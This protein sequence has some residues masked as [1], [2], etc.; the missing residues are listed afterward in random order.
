[1]PDK[2]KGDKTK[3]RQII[4]RLLFDD[5]ALGPPIDNWVKSYDTLLE[6]DK[7]PPVL[8]PVILPRFKMQDRPEESR[9]ASIAD[10]ARFW[11]TRSGVIAGAAGSTS[12]ADK[13]GIKIPLSN[14]VRSLSSP[15][16]S[17]AGLN[18]IV[19]CMQQSLE[20]GI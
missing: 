1:M 18:E 17:A 3:Q 13:H 16:A 20:T 12:T 10:T 4:L 2:K 7:V 14:V 15:L 8:K 5:E 9:L 11:Q 19:G 6:S